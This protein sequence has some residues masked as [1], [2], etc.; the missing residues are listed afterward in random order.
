MSL[1][2]A[3]A[4]LPGLGSYGQGQE[5]LNV[6][7]DISTLLSVV[8]RQSQLLVQ[9]LEEALPIL[10]GLT[11]RT[12]SLEKKPTSPGDCGCEAGKSGTVPP[13]SLGT[14]S[15]AS[16]SSPEPTSTPFKGR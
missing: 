16:P 5:M 7:R 15:G 13:P 4:G 6:I 12:T 11:N 9:C 1:M 10:E 14:P 2:T 8:Y 3:G